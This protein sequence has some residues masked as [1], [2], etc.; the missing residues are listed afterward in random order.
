MACRHLYL[1][2]V[3]PTFKEAKDLVRAEVLAGQR[4]L[5]Q[6]ELQAFFDKAAPLPL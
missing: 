4:A 5:K 1:P 3:T 2:A 6:K